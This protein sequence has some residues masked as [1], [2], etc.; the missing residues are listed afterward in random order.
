MLEKVIEQYLVKRV[1]AQGGMA[2]KFASVAHRGVAD[3]IVCLP[4]QT[5]FVELKTQGGRLSELQKVFADDMLRLGQNY[6]VLWT[7][8][9]VDQWLL[10]TTK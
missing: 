8:E 6:V 7:K 1:T 2:Y 3:R 5:W 4:S 9:D 10:T